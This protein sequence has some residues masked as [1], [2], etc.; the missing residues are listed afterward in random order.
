MSEYELMKDSGIEWVGEIPRHWSII[1]NKYV[2]HKVKE[3]CESWEGQ[4]V[5]SLTMKGVIVRDLI[6]PTG[7]M[8]TTFD[9]YQR[10]TCGD[11][12]MCLFDI[13]VTPRCVGRAYNKGVI[14][15]AY[16]RF[17]LTK[18]ADL[19]YYYYYYLMID[20]TK[21][22]LHLAKNLR[23]SFTEEQLGVLKVP[24]PPISE[25]KAIGVFLDKSCSDID[26]AIAEAKASIEDYKLLK[27]SIITKAVTKGLN[28]TVPMK[29]SGVEW[30]G[31]IPENWDVKP[32]KRVITDRSGGAWGEDSKHDDND[33]IC[34]RIA[35][36][37]FDRG[38]FKDKSI[39]DLTIR[40]YPQHQINSLTLKKGDIVVEKSG[41]GEK[42]PVGRAVLFD[43]DY[44]ALYANFT[45]RIRVDSNV[46]FPKFMEY[47]WRTMYFKT[48]TT[49]YI[50]QTTGIQNLDIS[51]LL[52]NE[53][54][55]LPSKEDQQ[56]IV[57]QLDFITGQID[58]LITE[59]AAMIA[60][61]EAYKKSLIY[62]VVT[63]KRKVC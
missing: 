24:L 8:P 27:Q 14:S 56:Q 3:I 11:L 63:G 38:V 2:M 55:C 41:G 22:L 7:K 10:V 54:I 51:S 60:D 17:Q 59:K 31:I 39:E 46:V 25:Q 62:E 35:D 15:P 12:L 32:L 5:L 19:N 16:T 36:F 52:R 30:I 58:N 43:K 21:E 18:L 23:H 33:R 45:D 6:N 28:P 26:T 44:L 1:A 20:N 48:T 9:G 57:F 40:N 29:D 37:D 4:D 50:K 34:M 61:L 49:K 53:K 42:T 47:W 13:D